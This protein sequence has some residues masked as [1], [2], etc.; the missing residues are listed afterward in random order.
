M[1]PNLSPFEYGAYG[2]PFNVVSV[3]VEGPHESPEGSPLIISRR[4]SDAMIAACCEVEV[5][6]F[7]AGA[8][9][10]FICGRR[11]G[12]AAKIPALRT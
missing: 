2:T 5:V 8:R 7:V 9:Q 1:R 10:Y 11:A 3:E 6:N 12:Q 4:D